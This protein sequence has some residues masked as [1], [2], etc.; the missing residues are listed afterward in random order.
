MLLVAAMVAAV[1]IRNAYQGL[2]ELQRQTEE[3]EGQ[4]SLL[5]EDVRQQRERA[6][7]SLRLIQQAEEPVLRRRLTEI[8]AAIA[9]SGDGGA[10]G[11]GLALDAAAATA[12]RSLERS[13]DGFAC[14]CCAGKKRSSPP[15][16]STLRKGGQVSDLAGKDRRSRHEDLAD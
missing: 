5:E 11:L 14:S 16:W 9:A 12:T 7:A 3:L 6:E 15:G 10:D 13:P 4:Q 2:P 8:R 1:Q